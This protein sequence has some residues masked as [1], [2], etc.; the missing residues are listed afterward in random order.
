MLLA[1]L[2]AGLGFAWLALSQE[3]HHERVGGHLPVS[4]RA[5]WTR[6]VIGFVSVALVL[7]LCT[8]SQGASFGS[9]LWT[10]LLSAAAMAVAFTLA[11]RPH[12]LRWLA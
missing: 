9:L 12:W 10:M 11:W 3:R 6:R 4:P 8:A 1:A 7:P 5:L 2:L